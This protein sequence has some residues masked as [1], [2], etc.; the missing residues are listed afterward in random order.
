M[1]QSLLTRGSIPEHKVKR[2]NPNSNN[3]IMFNS[4]I[5]STKN[6]KNSGTVGR[7]LVDV[8][9]KKTDAIT[10]N[11]KVGISPGP[12][13]QSTSTIARTVGQ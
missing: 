8:K 3:Q 2:Q 4:Q 13:L 10:F 1:K 12:E 7:N 11:M 6:N 9:F 5:Q